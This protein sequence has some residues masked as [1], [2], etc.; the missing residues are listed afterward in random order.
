MK[1]GYQHASRGD[2]YAAP[3]LYPR[4]DGRR[5]RPRR[6]TGL[7]VYGGL[8]QRCAPTLTPP[9][10]FHEADRQTTSVCRCARH[11]ER[12][13]KEL[14][15]RV[16]DIPVQRAPIDAGRINAGFRP[17]IPSERVAL[18]DEDLVVYQ[19]EQNVQMR[20]RHV[21]GRKLR[22]VFWRSLGV[23]GTDDNVGWDRQLPEPG[24]LHAEAW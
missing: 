2:G 16:P 19:T 6:G 1:L 23:S 10:G 20:V 7:V 22:V 18:V 12:L 13:V 17:C 4:A 24:F 21:F 3:P 15:G 11:P 8:R 14:Q 5:L 9:R